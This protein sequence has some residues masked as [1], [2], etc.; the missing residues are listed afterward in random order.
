MHFSRPVLIFASRGTG[1]NLCLNPRFVTKHIKLCSSWALQKHWNT[2]FQYSF[3]L[4]RQ[5]RN[6]CCYRFSLPP[7]ANYRLSFSV[8]LLCLWWGMIV[9]CAL[10]SRSPLSFCN[11]CLDCSLPSS[12][13]LFFVRLAPSCPRRTGCHFQW[14]HR[15]LEL[16]NQIGKGRRCQERRKKA[17]EIGKEDSC[18]NVSDFFY[19][20]LGFC[21]AMSAT[22]LGND[23]GI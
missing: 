12:S 1:T 13:A 19:L 18:S 21:R 22:V 3:S 15:G 8:V 7:A 23:I 5:N 2:S 14:S 10:G 11:S 20:V 4:V 9:T 17:D 6:R 16:K